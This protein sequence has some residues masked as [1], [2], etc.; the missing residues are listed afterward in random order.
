MRKQV[1][2]FCFLPLL[3]LAQK[4]DVTDLWSGRE[5]TLPG[6]GAW[7]LAAEHGRILSSGNGDVKIH[8]PALEDGSTLDAVLTCG[9]KRQKVKFHSPKPLIGLTMV[10]DNTAGRRVSTLHRYGVGLLAEPPLA[11]PGALLVTSQWPNQ[12]NNERILLFPDKRDFPLNIAGNRKEIS[13][14]CA[15]NPGSLSVLYDKKEQVLDLR[16]TFS[17]VVLRDGKRKV[18]VFT[19]EFDLDQIDNVLFIRQLAEEKQK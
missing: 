10:S 5:Q 19:P 2:L 1:I 9:E 7:I 17:Y 4:N 8:F 12:F 18:V 6:N 16:G 15:K 14:H 3:L 11:H 13:L